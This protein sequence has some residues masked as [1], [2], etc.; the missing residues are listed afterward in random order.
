MLQGHTQQQACTRAV[1]AALKVFDLLN[2]Y[3][4]YAD[5]CYP[6]RAAGSGLRLANL[7]GRLQPHVDGAAHSASEDAAVRSSDR[8]APARRVSRR[9]HNQ[10]TARAQQTGQP[11]GFA[12]AGRK[13]GAAGS[14]QGRSSGVPSRQLM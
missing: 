12:M 8:Q 4:I 5:V 6:A 2:I 9:P 10:I 3:D 1:T 13:L 7:L 14:L 11:E